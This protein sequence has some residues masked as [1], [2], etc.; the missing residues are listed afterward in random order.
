P[1]VGGAWG[2][3]GSFDHDT[4]GLAPRLLS[5]MSDLL[6]LVEGTAAHLRL[7]QIGAVADVVA[8]HTEGLQA[9][10]PVVTADALMNE[11]VRVFEVPD[12]R[13]RAYAV[14]G[15]RIADGGDALRLLL[16]A[17]FDPRREVVLP[18]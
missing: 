4:P 13:P 6:L 10:R 1:P 9:L 5:E 11:P 17:Q 16:D 12:F 7:L 14:G 8:L 3:P 2:L 15:V 18:S